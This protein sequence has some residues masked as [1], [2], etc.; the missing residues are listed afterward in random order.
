MNQKIVILNCSGLNHNVI[1]KFCYE[2]SLIKD[3]EFSLYSPRIPSVMNSYYYESAADP[4]ILFDLASPLLGK[5]VIV[6]LP[7]SYLNKKF[8][9]Q[10]LMNNILSQA[11]VVKTVPIL[12]TISAEI[13]VGKIT[14]FNKT[15]L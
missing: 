10:K 3:K 5:D 14:I 6:L 2:W 15:Y 7:L 8:Y 12:N 4:E 9:I 11:R 13:K 1:K